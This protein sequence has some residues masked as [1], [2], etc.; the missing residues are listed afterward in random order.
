M[1]TRMWAPRRPFPVP[2]AGTLLSV[3]AHAALL[4]AA[5]AGDLSDGAARPHAP[6]RAARVTFRGVGGERLHWVG[7][8]PGAADDRSPSGRDAPPPVAYVVPGHGGMRLVVRGRDGRRARVRG[9]GDPDAPPVDLPALARALAPVRPMSRLPAMP[10]PSLPDPDATL[11]VAGVLASA[12]DLARA[13]AR[14]EEFTRLPRA[15]LSPDPFGVLATDALRTLTRVDELPIPLVGNPTPRYP[16]ALERS[17]V[18]GRVVVE[19]LID[20]T[21]QV[22]QTSVR[23]VHG[24]N[25]LFVDAVR[26]VLP[27]LRF[28]PAQLKEHAVGVTVRQP[29]L[30]TL[31][32]GL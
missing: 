2:V 11:L 14:A 7:I 29:F 18:G 3:S 12:P 19:F 13:A 20:S 30:F 17:R 5:V 15:A 6:D 8:A 1:I 24:S 4:A 22:D 23:V 31:R 10:Q 21:G 28:L 25:V 9:A 16:A 27:E 26:R 32:R